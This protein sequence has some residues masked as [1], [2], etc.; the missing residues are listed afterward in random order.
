MLA[1]NL[2]TRGLQE[3]LDLL[4]YCNHT[5]GTYLSELRRQHGSPEPY[6]VRMWCL[7]NEMDGRGSCATSRPKNTDG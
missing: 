4:E 7:G 1:L 3:A 5:G 2:G 6:N